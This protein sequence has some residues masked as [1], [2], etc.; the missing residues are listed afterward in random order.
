V[1]VKFW[2]KVKVFLSDMRPAMKA[3]CPSA[4][5]LQPG[6]PAIFADLQKEQACQEGAAPLGVR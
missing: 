5:L 1:F 4:R 3:D 2:A 6:L